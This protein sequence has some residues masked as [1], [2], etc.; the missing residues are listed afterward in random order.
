LLAPLPNKASQAP[1]DR[2]ERVVR[3]NA[4]TGLDADLAASSPVAVAVAR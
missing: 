4:A 2:G 3:Q 1:L